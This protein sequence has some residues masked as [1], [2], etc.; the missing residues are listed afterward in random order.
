MSKNENEVEIIKSSIDIDLPLKIVDEQSIKLFEDG[1]THLS[2]S[3]ESIQRAGECFAQISATDWNKLKSRINGEARRWA[4]NARNVVVKNLH[5]AFAL[6]SG[7]L[8]RKARKLSP[9]D[10]LHILQHPIECAVIS[11]DCV[12]LDK[13]MIMA[14]DMTTQQINQCIAEDNSKSWIC[15]VKEQLARYRAANRAA[16]ANESKR[17]SVEINKPAYTLNNNGLTFK[18]KSMSYGQFAELAEDVQKLLNNLK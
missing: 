4:N 14:S 13:R 2:G 8:G 17:T 16:I 10:Q 6:M 3:I 7:V 15:S 9:S 11:D 18:R 1:L 5:P 12:L